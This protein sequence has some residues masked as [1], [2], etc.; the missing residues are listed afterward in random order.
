VAEIETAYHTLAPLL[1]TGAA[2]VFLVALLASGVSSSAVGT[3]AGQ[4]IMQGFVGF[5]IP[6]WVRRLVTMVPAIVVVAL[7]VNATTALVISQIVLSIALP[8][9]M[10]SL[11]AFTRRRDIMGQYANGRVTQAGAIAA[12]GLVLTLNLVL[13]AQTFGLPIPG[14]ASAG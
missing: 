10:L 4:M 6:V 8:L 2:G 14:L 13:I 11:L 3:M 5:T 1:G 7:G 9:P 12:T